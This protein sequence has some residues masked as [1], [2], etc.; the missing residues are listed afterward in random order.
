[1][2]GTGGGHASA[3][4]PNA[5]EP[6][7]WFGSVPLIVNRIIEEAL[8]Q[9][10]SDIHIEPFR[11]Q[12]R[13][14]YRVDGMLRIAG[15]VDS[16]QREEVAARI[17]ILADLDIAEKR[18]PQDGRMTVRPQTSRLPE[19]RLPEEI[20]LRVSTLPT[21]HGEKVV[22][23][24]LDRSDI[25]LDLEA[26]GFEPK[27]RS[28]FEAAIRRPH[29][30]VLVTGPTGSGKTTT[31]YAAL[32]ALDHSVLNVQTIE[33]PVEYELAGVNQAQARADIGFGFAEAL[34][35]FLRQDPDVVMVGEIRD[36]DTAEIAIRAALTGHLVLSTLHTNDAASTIGRLLDMGVAPYLVSAAV[37]LAAAQR[38]VRRVCPDC[39]SSRPITAD[40]RSLLGLPDV[41][42]ITEGR[43]CARCGGTGFRGRTA[44]FELLPMTDTLSE[45]VAEGAPT[46]QLRAEARSAGVRPLRA[47]AAAK[48]AVGQTTPDEAIRHTM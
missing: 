3:P 9:G 7:R 45:L 42:H 38:L 13:V 40:E 12:V 25:E 16:A 10:A 28:V 19:E 8:A 11:R 1:M 22:L 23:R 18:R 44:V 26:L 29:G 17:K 5:A 14:R 6:A 2:T 15:T 47:A 30:L 21:A 37:E 48:V 34:R 41:Q 46:H 24:I 33:D 32:S 27:E 39:S 43:G 20:D 31:L 4:A 35:A 36:R